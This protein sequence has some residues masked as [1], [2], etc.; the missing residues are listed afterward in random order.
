MFPRI[1]V[2]DGPARGAISEL[3]AAPG[4][5]PAVVG[6]EIA[7]LVLAPTG[8]VR[9]NLRVVIEKGLGADALKQLRP[10]RLSDIVPEVTTC[11]G[12]PTPTGSLARVCGI[13]AQQG[14]TSWA[15]LGALTLGEM[16]T[17][18]G[19]GPGALVGLIGAAVETVL[20]CASRPSTELV[21]RE[22]DPAEESGSDS[23][24][25]ALILHHEKARGGHALRR[26]LERHASGD[27]TA[28]VRAAA[29]LLLDAAD[30]AGDPRVALLDQAWKAAGDHRD[31]GIFA[32]RAL[33]LE[34]PTPTAV[35]VDALGL[36]AARVLQI[37]AQA[38]KRSRE[39]V[40]PTLANLAAD[41]AARLG[42]VCRLASVD[43][44]LADM[45]LPARTD[46][47]VAL[48]VWLAGPYLPVTG[49]TGWLATDPAGFRADTSRLLHDDG[50]VRQL[51]HVTAD[52]KAA[53]LGSTD[54]DDWLGGLP[55]VV[56]DGLVVA[57]SGHPVD[58]A[59]RLLSATGRAMTA[60]D[61]VAAW[62]AGLEVT[63]L[64]TRLG[65]DPRFVRVDRDHFELSEWGGEPF[66][67][68]TPQA[69]AELFPGAGRGAPTGRCE[70][71]IEVD[72]AALRGTTVP[73]PLSIVHALGVVCGGRR[74]F[75]TRYGPVA[76]S[77]APAHASRGSVRPVA[78]AAGAGP[79]D[80][81][82]FEFD[83]ATGTATVALLPLTS[84]AAG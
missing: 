65:R 20:A 78:L 53:G 46:P 40:G 36:S 35:L 44:A 4:S 69:P 30:R 11:P 77:H 47:R 17:W 14:A 42:P 71:R 1:D 25:L 38:Q 66:V 82:L 43:D 48:L 28:D 18:P 24:A 27:G 49:R 29:S 13:L 5:F 2:L 60:A 51:D 9:R 58:V 33:Q 80:V 34:G 32:H 41:V 37:Q 8:D 55:V 50:G 10:L 21:E 19:V 67:E 76:L 16:A 57:V 3:V 83:A 22:P 39:A 68:P 73:V 61:L 54:V 26:A 75:A 79:G 31:R 15:A 6:R 62:S 81:L 56:V 52:L 70:L 7:D 63:D 12:G 64:D 74:T 23:A 84:A 72:A 59:E 45:G